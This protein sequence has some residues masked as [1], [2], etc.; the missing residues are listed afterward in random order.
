M[1]SHSSRTALLT[2]C[3][4]F[5]FGSTARAEPPRAEVRPAVV[6]HAGEAQVTLDSAQPDVTFH[7]RV[8]SAHGVA[9]GRGGSAVFG[10]AAYDEICTAPCD[11]TLATGSYSL[12][13]SQDNGG[14]V[15]VE[16]RVNI[17]GPATVR[18]EYTSYRGVRIAGLVTAIA[19]A[20]GGM[21]LMLVPVFSR[22]PNE[23]P[24]VAP[25]IAGGVIA[26]GGVLVGTILMLK[27]DEADVHV[28]PA[29]VPRA[30]V[31][32]GVAWA[33]RF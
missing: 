2:A 17:R 5:A 33:G 31:A 8:G 20:V 26:G 32:R 21:T 19:S 11:V 23:T 15:A 28:E 6:V 7:R 30:A 29:P 14:P 12:A 10:M 22:E 25:I 9:V 24:S 18:G 27:G 13:L 4:A 16:D 1:L 3:A